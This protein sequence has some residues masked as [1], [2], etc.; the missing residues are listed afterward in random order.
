MRHKK[1]LTQLC[2]KYQFTESISLSPN[3]QEALARFKDCDRFKI[4]CKKCGKEHIWDSV[5]VDA[6]GKSAT[7]TLAAKCGGN[8]GGADF[9]DSV[10]SIKNKLA[11]DIRQHIKS[12]YASW[13]KCEDDACAFRTRRTPLA[14]VKGGAPRCPA[15][16]VGALQPEMAASKLHDQ[17]LFYRFIF[18]WDKG[19]L[20]LN[21]AELLSVGRHAGAEDLIRCY[22]LLKSHVD[23]VLADSA[24][25]Q[26]DLTQFARLWC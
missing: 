9:V 10:A 13:L 15:C 24:Y 26:V 14:S 25:D 6:D 4:P 21:P 8:C 16:G 17:L 19:L 3:P 7:P 12:Y 2:T 20:G 1:L 23:K 5:F 11:F 18:D 22:A